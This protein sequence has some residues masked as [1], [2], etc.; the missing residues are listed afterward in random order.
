MSADPATTAFGHQ[1]TTWK[2]RVDSELEGIRQELRGLRKSQEDAR[3]DAARREAKAEAQAD[4]LSE[5]AA[6]EGSMLD[7]LNG[8]DRTL[9]RL[10]EAIEGLN[11]RAPFLTAADLKKMVV[12]VLTALA[13]SGATFA[14]ATALGAI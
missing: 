10:A 2:M 13:I 11:A 7:R 9:A 4:L 3:V 8:I 1:F 14:I 5:M 12:A 6:R